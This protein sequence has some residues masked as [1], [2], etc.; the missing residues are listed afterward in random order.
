M[1]KLFLVLNIVLLA[2]GAVAL[3]RGRIPLR[4]CMF[5]ACLFSLYLVAD[6]AWLLASSIA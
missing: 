1:P 4:P 3:N 6:L 2:A 5:P